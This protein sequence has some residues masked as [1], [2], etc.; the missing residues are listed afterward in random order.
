VYVF[1]VQWKNQQ[2]LIPIASTNTQ[3]KNKQ[4]NTPAT[5]TQPL[6]QHQDDTTI[7]LLAPRLLVL[8]KSQYLASFSSSV[9]P[10]TLFRHHLTAEMNSHCIGIRVFIFSK[11]RISTNPL[12]CLLA[13]SYSHPILSTNFKLS[14]YRLL[15][16]YSVFLFCVRSESFVFL[17]FLPHSPVYITKTFWH[18]I[19][20]PGIMVGLVHIRY[21]DNSPHTWLF[22]V[23]SNFGP[24]LWPPIWQVAYVCYTFKLYTSLRH[25]LC[26]K[27]FVVFNI[28]TSPIA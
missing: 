12:W 5:N 22:H 19:W 7:L 17:T 20:T 23:S 15:L 6:I 9:Y 11:V 21:Q 4:I 10:C 24:A 13:L 1:H 16:G 27:R 3:H 26:L 25:L 8:L 2:H 18:N 14:I 28:S